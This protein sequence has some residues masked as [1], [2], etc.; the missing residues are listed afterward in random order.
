VK[1]TDI[2]TLQDFF[3]E[4]KKKAIHI[5]LGSGKKIPASFI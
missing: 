3:N 1:S 2:A 5:I 4:E